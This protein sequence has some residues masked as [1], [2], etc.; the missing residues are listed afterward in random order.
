MLR[1]RS[2]IMETL[3]WLS[4]MARLLSLTLGRASWTL[5]TIAGQECSSG[6]QGSPPL[7]IPRLQTMFL[8][9]SHRVT[10]STCAAQAKVNSA[11][12]TDQMSSAA[13]NPAAYGCKKTQ[14]FP[15]GLAAS[16]TLFKATDR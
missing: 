5:A 6:Q 12:F 15:S 1:E 16:K 14:K 3:G 8:V 13:I 11:L 4:Q 10:V 2:T 7:E 9:D